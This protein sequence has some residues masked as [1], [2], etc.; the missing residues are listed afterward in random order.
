MKTTQI[1][2]LLAT[3]V[4]L[5]SL[6]A[7]AQNDYE[8]SVKDAYSVHVFKPGQVDATDAQVARL[9]APAGFRVTKYAQNV[10]NPRMLAVA[11]N[12]DVYVSD[13]TKGTVMLVRDA[14]KD[15][16]ADLVKEV[17]KR[18]DLHGLALRGGKLYLTAIRE[19]F[20]ADIRSDGSLGALKTLYRDLPDAGQ[21]PNLTM[22]F[23][24]YV[25][26]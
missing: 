6:V 17:A 3:V 1:V 21:H 12:G 7:N 26:L 10:G 16:K 11:P 4:L 18:A 22:G 2:S 9:K 15:G 23:G 5:S 13:R 8:K 25:N 14:N 24:P 19:L 20:V